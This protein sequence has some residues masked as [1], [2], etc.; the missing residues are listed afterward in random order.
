VCMRERVCSCVCTHLCMCACVSVSASVC[1][2]EGEGGREATRES[3]FI[4]S[5]NWHL[6]IQNYATDTNRGRKKE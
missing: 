5:T 6:F 4:L 3:L 1:V 2:C